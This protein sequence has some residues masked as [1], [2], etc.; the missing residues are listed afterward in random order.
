MTL[1]AS[2]HIL[3]QSSCCANLTARIWRIVRIVSC[4]LVTWSSST[5]WSDCV[6]SLQT[7]SQIV[8]SL[9][10]F[11]DHNAACRE[12]KCLAKS[13]VAL[14]SLDTIHNQNKIY[15]VKILHLQASG[16]LPPSSSSS[17][18]SSDSDSDSSQNSSSD[19]L[20]L[21]PAYSLLEYSLPS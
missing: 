21:S 2:F 17:S 4:T 12:V 6:H 7:G 11:E 14:C 3:W 13:L 9:R 5:R 20:L 1:T 8:R 16:D 15:F 10:S 19:L 18:S